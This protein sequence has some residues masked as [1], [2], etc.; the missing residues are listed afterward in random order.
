[1]ADE[2]HVGVTGTKE[3][4]DQ[5]L[6]ECVIEKKGL[7]RFNGLLVLDKE[8][9]SKVGKGMIIRFGGHFKGENAYRGAIDDVNPNDDGKF[10]IYVTKDAANEEC[11]LKQIQF[12]A[13]DPRKKDNFLYSKEEHQNGKGYLDKGTL[14]SI[15]FF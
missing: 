14:I 8:A 11:P 2:Y 15:Q 9:K 4:G 6:V 12:L 13:E 3:Q 7:H 10:V 5:L 1:M